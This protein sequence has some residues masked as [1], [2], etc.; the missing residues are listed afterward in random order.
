MSSRAA[1]VGGGGGWG[2]HKGRQGSFYMGGIFFYCTSMCGLCLPLSTQVT[3]I[4]ALGREGA[5]RSLKTLQM[6][7]QEI[8]DK[9]FS[10][11]PIS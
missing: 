3:E 2:G 6:V 9:Q 1:G 10:E 11:D 7:K 5:D 4:F 8:L